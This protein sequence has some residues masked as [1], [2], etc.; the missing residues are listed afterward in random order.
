M[1]DQHR[2]NA[3][4]AAVTVILGGAAVLALADAWR[5]IVRLGLCDEELGYVLLAPLMIVWLAWVKRDELLKCTV[6]HG[7]A[8]LV[9]L[10]AGLAL[11]RY[12]FITDP[13]LWR[14][15]AVLT[16]AGAVATGIGSSAL[17]TLAPSFAAFVFLIPVSPYGRY[18]VAAPL[19]K[20]TAEATQW[21]CDLVG[22]SVDRAGNLLS[23]NGIDVTV[24]EACNGMRMVMTL[25]MIC[26]VVTFT[27]KLRPYAR[28]LVLAA[29][30]VVAVGSNVA[31]LVPTI[32][33]FGHRPVA[34]AERF[35]A[36]SGWV[37]TGL[38]LLLLL[39]TVNI[40]RHSAGRLAAPM[41]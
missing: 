29:S 40:V 37:M 26:Y 28:L 33:M 23:I 7:W 27:V 35:H 20:I 14:A 32:W 5:D 21:V 36:A 19:Q 41:A 30:P 31:R 25:F 24:A 12:G 10:I 38:A 17:A 3:S 15:G 11:N 22:I 6:R 4:D 8:G 1:T 18:H 16:L 34:D 9:I 2:I 13:V 39:A